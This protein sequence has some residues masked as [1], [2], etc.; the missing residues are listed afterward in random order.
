MSRALALLLLP[1]GAL[2]QLQSPPPAEDLDPAPDVLHVRLRAAASGDAPWLYAYNGQ[3]PGPTLRAKVG[4][5]L[6]VELEN[7][8]DDPTTIHWHGVAVPWAMDGVTWM[9][10]PVAP[11]ETFEYR[12]TLTRPGTFWYHPHFDTARQVDAGLYGVL[13]VEDPAEPAVDDL[14]LVFDTV[15]EHG[16]PRHADLGRVRWWV[17]GQPAPATVSRRGG[18]LLRVRML[19]ASN[20][21]YLALRWP[22][23]RQIAGDQGLLPRLHTP[24]RVLLGPGQRAEFEWRVGE[25]GFTVENEPHSLHGGDAFGE[26]APLVELRVD[27]P[28]PAPDGA[29]WP[30]PGGEPSEDPPYADI[31]YA[32]A[33]S[34][35]T[36]RWMINGERF[37]DVTVEAVPLGAEVVLELRNLSPTEHPFHLHGLHFEVLSVNGTPPPLRTIA[38]TWNLAV[39]DVVRVRFTADNPGDWMAH[40]HILPH[41][42]D[43]MMTV[44]RVE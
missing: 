31:V 10:A 22:D 8:L 11:G 24:E 1:L 9:G 44:L 4:D 14:V 7:T 41:A 13:V 39:H 29:P 6:V 23:L 27:A 5:T 36:Q 26:P 34:D 42:E 19:N 43:G 25:A 18:S 15:A 16:A 21:G 37:P 32:F 20:A 3:N 38:D 28:A 40:C 30:F 12:F 35:R 33:G 17:N 2:G